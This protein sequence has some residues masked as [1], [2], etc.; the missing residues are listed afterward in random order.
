MTAPPASSAL[1][2]GPTQLKLRRVASSGAAS[3]K[4]N[5]ESH[6]LHHAACG[7]AHCHHG[8]YLSLPTHLRTAL[9]GV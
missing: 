6:A 3:R 1:P 4:R 2:A 8:N 5:A 9:G 7:D